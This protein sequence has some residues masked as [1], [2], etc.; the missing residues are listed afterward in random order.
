MVLVEVSGGLGNQMF[1]YACG[2]AL[3]IR[4]N[5]ALA[6]DLSWF[7][8]QELRQFELWRYAIRHEECAHAGLLSL[9]TAHKLRRWGERLLFGNRRIREKSTGYDDTVFHA[10]GNLYLQG[11]WQSEKYF[12]DCKE[13]IKEELC[14]VEPLDAAN[15]AWA[16]KIQQSKNA[17]SVHIRRGD[18][19]T[20]PANQVT[21]EEL[22]IEYYNNALKIMEALL[23]EI[24]VFVF[25]NDLLWA[26]ENLISDAPMFFVDANDEHNG[27]KDMRLMSL[28]SH[29][30]IA[31]STFS[32]WG[33]WL[34][35]NPNKIVIS[36]RTWFKKED[37]NHDDIIPED[38]IVLPSR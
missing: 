24:N 17:V 12:R 4:N 29:N 23:G 37:M 15:Q 11:F 33:A 3:A 32:W 25:S 31:N 18:Y 36:P 30:I 34:N 16:N 9:R 28:C 7:E 26:R 6:L 20:V 10:K 1:Q 5:A 38:W 8:R 35:R 21:F 2:K 13:P 22:S 19:L 14:L 27:H